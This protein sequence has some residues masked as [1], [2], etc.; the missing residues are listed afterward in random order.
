MKKNAVAVI[1][2]GMEEGLVTK[3]NQEIIDNESGIEGFV[4]SKMYFPIYAPL[5]HKQEL[6]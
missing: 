1:L 6:K 4:R 3:V 5:V 2:E